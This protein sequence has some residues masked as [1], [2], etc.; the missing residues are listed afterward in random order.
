M[1]LLHVSRK[2]ARQL[3]SIQMFSIKVLIKEIQTLS[4][5]LISS[6]PCLVLPYYHIIILHSDSQAVLSAEL[7]SPESHSP[8][9][10]QMNETPR[11]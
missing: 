11:S 5:F 9:K 7:E 1:N 6:T 2:I 10:A 3:T 4:S 8:R